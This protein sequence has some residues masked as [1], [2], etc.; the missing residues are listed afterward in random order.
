MLGKRYVVGLTRNFSVTLVL[1]K[2]GNGSLLF[3]LRIT[4]N[5]LSD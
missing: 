2:Y 5:L 3:F 4:V 1:E